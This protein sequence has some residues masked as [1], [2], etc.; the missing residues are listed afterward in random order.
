[1]WSSLKSKNCKKLMKK[2]WLK[3]WLTFISSW[4]YILFNYD[5]Q[6]VVMALTMNPAGI[7]TFDVGAF[8]AKTY[9]AE[10]LR[11]V[12]EGVTINI[13]KNGKAV[14]VLQ[15]KSAIQNEAA[16]NAHKRIL[17]RAQRMSELREKEGAASLTASDLKELK[18]EGRKY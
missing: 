2:N 5:Y 10:L 6:E 8:D 14:A 15:G 16:M 12:K 13:T 1:M 4:Y 11:K 17:A 7:N 18:N 9:F 3:N